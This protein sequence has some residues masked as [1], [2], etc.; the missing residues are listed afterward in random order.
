M[1]EGYIK[2]HRKTINSQV[3]QSEGLFKVWM[4]CL[5]KANHKGQWVPIK[6]G[7]STTE[8]WVGPGQFIFGRK[9]AAKELRMKPSTVWKRII[10]LKNMQ[11]LNIE[12]NTHYSV[13][14]VISWAFYQGNEKKGTS[15]VTG[16]EQPS[17]TNKNEKNEKNNIYSEAQEMPHR[18]NPLTPIAKRI[19]DHLNQV[20]NRN[21]TYSKANLQIIQ[22]RLNEGH[23]E[24]ACKRVIETKWDDPDFDK[25]YFRPA[26]LFRPT[27][28]EGYLNEQPAK[29]WDHAAG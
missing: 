10:K 3:F 15:K 19:I 6:T 7:R 2:V 29:R 5:L 25:K 21:F 14:T 18:T 26:T 24:E 22:A 20:G 13:I 12:S 16:K 11:N 8:V 27:K 17:N 4:W 1:N 28:F 9:S 23:T